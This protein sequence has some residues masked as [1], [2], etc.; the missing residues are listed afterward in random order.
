MSTKTI[1]VVGRGSGWQKVGI[2]L[3]SFF[4]YPNSSQPGMFQTF[5]SLIII[6]QSTGTR[7]QTANSKQRTLR[8]IDL[9]GLC[10][11]EALFC[12][13]TLCISEK[14]GVYYSRCRSEE[15]SQPGSQGRYRTGTGQTVLHKWAR[16]QRCRNMETACH[17]ILPEFLL[18]VSGFSWLNFE[19]REDEPI[20]H[21]I[22]IVDCNYFL[23]HYF[24][25]Q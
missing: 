18:N 13:S 21:F 25:Y 10:S 15:G 3:G 4:F 14:T 16:G 2:K 19:L 20:L 1:G 12:I 5:A 9:I 7:G 24:L 11:P 8:L 23:L 17:K 22:N 6:L